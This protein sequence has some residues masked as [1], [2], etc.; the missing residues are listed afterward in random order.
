M[1]CSIS[2]GS[3]SCLFIWAEQATTI[4]MPTKI[5]ISM[6]KSVNPILLKF[7][8]NCPSHKFSTAQDGA[9]YG[10]TADWSSHSYLLP[11]CGSYSILSIEQLSN[12]VICVL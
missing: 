1:L 4:L 12:I 6:S 9:A 2:A 8:W 10:M 11:S 7:S 5:L 3:R